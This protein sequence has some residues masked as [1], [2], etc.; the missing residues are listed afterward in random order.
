MDDELA[1]FL[2]ARFDLEVPGEGGALVLGLEPEELVADRLRIDRL[3][4]AELAFEGGR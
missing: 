3:P 4:R 1:E 2:E